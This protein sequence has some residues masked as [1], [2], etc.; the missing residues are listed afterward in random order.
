MRTLCR[1]AA[2]LLV[3]DGRD[4][5]PLREASILVDGQRR[6]M[7]NKGDGHAVFL[8]LSEGAHCFEVAAPGFQTQRRTFSVQTEAPVE[9]VNMWY[10]RD[11]VKLNGLDH[12]RFKFSGRGGLPMPG[13]G[14]R[15]TLCTGCGG[16]RVVETA[17]KGQRQLALSS[18]YT[19]QMLYQAYDAG[20]AGQ[21]I[22]AG[23]D[24]GSGRYMLQKPLGEKLAAGAVLRPVWNLETDQE[25]VAVLPRIG[26]F[27]PWDELEFT[28]ET[29]GEKI[30]KLTLPPAPGASQSAIQF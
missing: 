15:V 10:A 19:P 24:W 25:A 21:I 26:L 17:Q 8:N 3:L 5:S 1:A 9:V 30:Q 7:V 4:K 13:K 11:S 27:M 12:F 2:V 14:V 28:F 29:E 6:R 16:L 20:K 18:G 23:F 22:F